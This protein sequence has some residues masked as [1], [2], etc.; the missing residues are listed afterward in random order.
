VLR[1]AAIR[2]VNDEEFV[3]WATETG[4]YMDPKDPAGTWKGLDIK[5]KIFS[6]L[7]PL[8]DKAPGRN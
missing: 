7:R 5:A 2:A 1:D 3:E 8:L 4:Y 6:D